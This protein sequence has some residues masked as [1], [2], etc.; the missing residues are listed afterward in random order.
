VEDFWVSGGRS[1]SLDWEWPLSKWG[2]ELERPL[3]ELVR[4]GWYRHLSCLSAVVPRPTTEITSVLFLQALHE[5]WLRSTR[6]CIKGHS[7]KITFCARWFSFRKIP[8]KVTHKDQVLR[9]SGRAGE[10]S[11]S[12]ELGSVFWEHGSL[13]F[14]IFKVS[15]YAA[16]FEGCD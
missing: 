9:Q 7:V 13:I 1:R 6:Y 11:V 5:I 15:L 16:L 4:P 8:R 3:A 2:G 14:F 12:L 10:V